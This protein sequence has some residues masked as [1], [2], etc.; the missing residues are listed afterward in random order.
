MTTRVLCVIQVFLWAGVKSRNT[1][2]QIRNSFKCEFLKKFVFSLV[3]HIILNGTTASLY[4]A[5]F[6]QHS[7]DVGM[8]FDVVVFYNMLNDN[9]NTKLVKS[10]IISY[11]LFI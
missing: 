9:K 4:Q 3:R 8:L 1:E 5:D 2:L 11:N 6:F 10:S 7:F